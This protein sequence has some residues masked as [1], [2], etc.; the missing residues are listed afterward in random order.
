MADENN[1]GSITFTVEAESK[2]VDKASASMEKMTKSAD[3]VDKSLGKVKLE[4]DKYGNALTKADKA[5]GRFIDSTGKMREKNGQFVRGLNESN[6]SLAKFDRLAASAV[7]DLKNMA[8]AGAAAA[9]VLGTIAAANSQFNRELEAQARQA[10]V[11]VSEYQKLAFAAS[12]AGIE[13]EK[14]GD[15]TKDVQDKVGDFLATGGGEL[16]DFFE[17]VAPK[18]GVTADQFRGLSG[19]AALGL[20]IQ[21]LEKA[22]VSQEEAIFYTESLAD[23]ASRLRGVFGGTGESIAEAGR[24]MDELGFSIRDID[25][26]RAA[27]LSSSFGLLATSV[28]N[29]TTQIV[30]SFDVEIRE[31]LETTIQ[32]INKASKGFLIITDQFRELDRRQSE[33]GL[34]SELGKIQAEINRLRSGDF[35]LTEQIFG[36][37]SEASVSKRVAELFRQM[38][39]I[40]KRIREIREESSDAEITPQSGGST[41]AAPSSS[42]GVADLTDK[43]A[44]L[45]KQLEQNVTLYG[46]T[47]REVAKV[48]AR[49]KALL[50]AREQGVE[51]TTEQQYK[52]ETLVDEYYNL[53]E[54][55]EAAAKA[56]A[57][58]G[59]IGSLER[60]EKAWKEAQ[61]LHA[62]GLLTDKELTAYRKKLD[63]MASTAGNAG[64]KAGDEFAGGFIDAA[65]LG[66]A[67]AGSLLSGDFSGIGSSIGGSL[68][69]GISDSLGGGF[70]G[71]LAGGLAG[72]LAGSLISGILSGS[73]TK[74]TASGFSVDFDAGEIVSAQLTESFKKSS[75]FGSSR[76][77]EYTDLAIG[78][79]D[80]L[81]RD[82]ESTSKAISAQAE[83]LGISLDGFSGTV[84][85]RKG[86][87][88]QAGEDLADSIADAS[89]PAIEKWQEVGESSAETFSFLA[90]IADTVNDAFKNVGRDFELATEDFAEYAAQGL[91]DQYKIQAE[92]IRSQIAAASEEIATIESERFTGSRE[93]GGFLRFRAEQE[94]RVSDLN[95]SIS[96]LESE[97][98]EVESRISGVGVESV[99]TVRDS[100]LKTVTDIAGASSDIEAAVI[101]EGLTQSFKDNFRS[102]SDIL[103]QAADDAKAEFERITSDFDA[104]GITL[105]SSAEQ[106]S[107]I[108]D[109]ATSPEQQAAILAAAD[110]LSDY[111]GAIED[112][113]KA[114]EDAAN[115]N[116]AAVEKM[117]SDSERLLSSA[118]SDYR[119]ALSDSVTSISDAAQA[120]RD[121]LQARADS[122][123]ETISS[124]KAIQSA[125]RSGLSQLSGGGSFVG[126]SASLDSVIAS[127]RSGQSVD[128]SMISDAVSG[129]AGLSEDQFASAEEMAFQQ[130]VIANKLADIDRITGD[131]I[132]VEERTLAAINQQ[133][134]DSE[135]SERRQIK[136]LE[137]QFSELEAQTNALLGIDNSVKTVADAISAL[138]SAIEAQSATE[139]L[140]SAS[141]GQ[142]VSDADIQWTINE[143][144]SRLGETEEAWNYLYNRAKQFGVSISRVEQF[145]PGAEDWVERSGLPMFSVGGYTGSSMGIVHPDEYVLNSAATNQIGVPAL[146][147]LN[148]GV[149]PADLYGRGDTIDQSLIINE[150]RA[151]NSM[152]SAAYTQLIADQRQILSYFDDVVEG[153][154]VRIV[155]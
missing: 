15:I 73:E 22:N 23:E 69:K 29:A 122:S 41:G 118:L 65:D 17:N 126:S 24:R 39:A 63:E 10:G 132:T 123:K 133:I 45:E 57:I 8:I 99:Q 47:E 81:S 72:G 31:S 3:K 111:R 1:I 61:A 53:K 120:E 71:S 88:S 92:K 27:A 95:K 131:Q 144:V 82:I 30:A 9:G 110:A 113:A 38:D 34:V 93:R 141:S 58:K 147:A 115:A 79:L 98:S 100:I 6:G 148:S 26:N 76:W 16:A 137:D 125:A 50:L 43:L 90:D 64:E 75:F 66:S 97:L 89:F 91:V 37:D 13:Q 102:Q 28:K 134:A 60:Y 52:I 5:A 70:G 54:A 103:Q 86:E 20:F 12:Q 55:E 128:P 127:L 78:E 142:A 85:R 74:K 4:T 106:I 153:N 109:A 59:R 40:G 150:L 139:A 33:I 87:L 14:F 121:L 83:D 49:E 114:A 140:S 124:L 143:A 68:S 19:P 42:A 62:Q 152:M 119:G 116:A 35:S 44:G 56:D 101:F 138:R 7:S 67:V 21:T 146:N 105:E 32:L 96:S 145:L 51:L 46:K 18:V 77:T 112:Q 80:S 151:N 84:Q 94:D 108:F 36:D 136:A 149:N 107:A 2:G 11:S 117:V 25:V 155:Q 48:E 135:D 104:G 154:S 129:F 130:A